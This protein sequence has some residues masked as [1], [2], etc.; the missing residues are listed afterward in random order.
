MLVNLGSPWDIVG[1]SERRLVLNESNEVTSDQILS[2]VLHFLWLN[3]SSHNQVSFLRFSLSTH[4][5]GD[6]VA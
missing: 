3:T 2:L 1:H 6:K 5:V 4:F